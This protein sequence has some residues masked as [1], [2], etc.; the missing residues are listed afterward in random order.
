MTVRCLYPAEKAGEYPLSGLYL[1]RESIRKVDAEQDSGLLIYSNFIT[2]LDG[3]ISLQN[4]VSG[5]FSVPGHIA[6]RRDWRLY[7]ELAAQADVLITSARYFRQLDK[8]CAQDLLPV[9]REDAY[10]DLVAWR[11]QQGMQAQ[12]DVLIVSASLDIPLAA[13]R[14]L[15]H[16][17]IVVMTP[18]GCDCKRREALVA[19]G[20]QVCESGK[21]QVSGTDI[22]RLLVKL[23]YRSA[24]MIAGPAVHRTLLVD[25]VLD[26]LFLT[27]HFSL[28]GQDA[29]HSILQG[30]MQ[31]VAARLCSL[32]L[33][34]AGQQIFAQYNMEKLEKA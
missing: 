25:G 27:T 5:E 21:G 18:E 7:Q 9:G 29:F 10:Q 34:E 26:R 3:R 12:P 33:D 28:L 8:G 23:G 22:K 20:V 14:Y 19:A 15:E 13:L 32:Y 2:S 4:A 6:N 16:R 1:E 17:S 30:D 31:P 24:Y 11:L